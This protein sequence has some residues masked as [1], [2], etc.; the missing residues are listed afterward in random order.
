MG[1]HSLDTENH[2]RHSRHIIG[3]KEVVDLPEWNIHSLVTKAD[4]GARGSALDV[5]NIQELP[6]DRVRFEVILNR[7]DR[8]NRQVVETQLSGH[9]R[10]RSSTGHL[11]ER[12]KVKTQ[13]KIGRVVKEVE[14][15]LVNR[16][17][18]ICRLL[19]GRK[20]LEEDFLVDSSRKYICG[21]RKKARK[22]PHRKKKKTHVSI[23]RKH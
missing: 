5:A 16:K 22:K 9:T 4:T 18:M 8:E 13:V 2:E 10:V 15:S 20:A 19:L 14:F 21:P 11:Q 7:K 23:K 3:W 1:K 12:Y 6:D 17:G